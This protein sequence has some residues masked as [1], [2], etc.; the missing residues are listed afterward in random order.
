M[1]TNGVETVD[2]NAL[3]GSDSV[4]INDLS[5]TDVT[6]TNIDLAGTLGGNAADN[7]ADSVTVNGTGG[8]DNIAVAGNGSGADVTGLATAG[9]RQARGPD[10]GQPV[11]EH[12]GRGG[13]RRRERRG[14]RHQGVRGRRRRLGEQRAA[15]PR[16]R[17]RGS[18]TQ[19][20]DLT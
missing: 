11:R 4:T 19:T 14:R 16:P 10:A 6:Q 17:P 12:A 9:L 20:G 15:A 8:D 7:T 1:D 5:G 3:T 13:Q 2:F 18:A